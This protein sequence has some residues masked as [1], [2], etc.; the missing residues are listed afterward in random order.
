MSA[1]ADRAGRLAALVGERELDL[2]LVTNLVNVRYLTGFSGTNAICL[3][4]PSERIFATDF[5]YFER[6]KARLHDYEV[7]RAKE[8]LLGLLGPFLDEREGDGSPARLGFDDAHLTVRQHAKLSDI[9][10]GRAELVAAGGLVEELRAVKDATELESMRRAAAL[11]DDLYRWLAAEHGLVGHTERAVAIAL[12]RRAMDLGAHGLSF[13]PIIAA[14]EN[15][16]LPHAEQRDVEIPTGTLVI[17][18]LGCVLDGYCSDCT[19]TFAT[20]EIDG[21]ASECYELV[22]E[23]Q[24]AA[25]ADVAPGADVREV[26]ATA[27]R[28]I[29]GAGRGEQFGH[30]TG[31]GVGLE[32]HEAPRIAP[33]AE[34]SLADGNV[35]TI[36]PG[37]YVPGRFG[38]R[39]EDLVAV[40]AD[41]HDVLSSTPKDLVSVA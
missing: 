19:R 3:V 15:G 30:G 34:G 7:R 18:D 37:V 11:A 9:V 23:A 14:A 16:A 35:V 29:D 36:E 32:V 13:P 24:A 4:G 21:E 10:S 6:M 25:L 12:E 1:L 38:V 33:T 20:G 41:G 8:D 27:R 40:T 5:R 26:D 28:K 31:H 22:R 2:L 39:I 17:V